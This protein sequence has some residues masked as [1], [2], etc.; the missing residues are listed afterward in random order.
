MRK[1]KKSSL[2]PLKAASIC[3]F[4]VRVEGKEVIN[5]S[6]NLGD[7]K[8]V[9]QNGKYTIPHKFKVPG[10]GRAESIAVYKEYYTGPV[11]ETIVSPIRW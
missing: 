6:K 1:K 10:K 7:Y 2:P 4:L 5:T 11:F 8:M 3:S 9:Q